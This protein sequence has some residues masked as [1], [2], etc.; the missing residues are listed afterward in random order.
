MDKVRAGVLV[1]S[2]MGGLTVF[3]NG[4]KT[5]VEKGHRMISPFFIPYAITNMC[6]PS[7]MYCSVWPDVQDADLFHGYQVLGVPTML[8]LIDF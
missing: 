3:Q 7:P 4:V 5:L 2:G 8:M 6:V 1:G